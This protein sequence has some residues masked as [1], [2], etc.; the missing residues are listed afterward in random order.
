MRSARGSC[1]PIIRQCFRSKRVARILREY[2]R[3]AVKIEITSI[4]QESRKHQVMKRFYH[5]TG[6]PCPPLN[7]PCKPRP[8]THLPEL[9]KCLKVG[10]AR[11]TVQRTSGTRPCP[12]YPLSPT[13]SPTFLCWA[14][15]SL[16]GIFL[17]GT[18]QLLPGAFH[19]QREALRSIRPPPVRHHAPRTPP[20]GGHRPCGNSN[21]R[22]LYVH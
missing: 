18:T 13:N 20:T 2:V 22:V 14:H 6:G 11:Y 4:G 16:A 9:Q 15:S 21:R 8:H 5:V 10:M 7:P 12:S 3:V 1:D 19:Q 17:R